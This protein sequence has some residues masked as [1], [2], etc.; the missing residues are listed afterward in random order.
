MANAMFNY[1]YGVL[2]NEI[3]SVLVKQGFNVQISFQ[4]QPQYGKPTL[5]YDV[6]EE[7]RAQIVDRVV[8]SLLTKKAHPELDN[9]H[10]LTRDSKNRLLKALLERL[11]T[12]IRYHGRDEK[13]YEEIIHLQTQHMAKYLRG[14]ESAYHPFIVYW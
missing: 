3:W 2:Y 1:G 5:V 4:H 8:I 11:R 6:I 7:Y 12:P 14:E 13:T 9:E 10:H